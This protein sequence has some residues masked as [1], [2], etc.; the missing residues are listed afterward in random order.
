MTTVTDTD[1][2]SL[3][4]EH[5]VVGTKMEPQLATVLHA[6]VATVSTL[7]YVRCP[8]LWQWA[9]EKCAGGDAGGK[10]FGVAHYQ[11]GAPGH[12]DVGVSK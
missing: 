10:S 8:Q 1:H 3:L 7:G 11:T 9:T 5:M 6:H 4:G 12:C 2:L